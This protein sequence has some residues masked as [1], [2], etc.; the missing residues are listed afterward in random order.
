MTGSKTI[1]L[2]RHTDNSGDM[3]TSQGVIDAVAIGQSLDGAFDVAASSGAQRATQTVGCLLGGLGQAVPG[4][5]VVIEAL[6][7]TVE[8]RWRDAYHK[9]GAGDLASLRSADPDLVA[10]DSAA[11]AEGLRSLLAMVPDGGRA[12]AV[13]HSPTNEAAVLGLTGTMIPPLGK[14]EYVVVVE[15]PS[16]FSV[17]PPGDQSLNA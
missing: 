1:V 14:G 9:A 17:T 16:G 15:S 10:T 2:V 5:V 12:L 6:R 4:G 7:S 8:D 3:L 11:L 13:G